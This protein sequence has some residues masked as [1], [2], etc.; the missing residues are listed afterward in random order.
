MNFLVAVQG[1]EEVTLSEITIGD[2]M[3]EGNAKRNEAYFG[4]R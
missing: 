2:A 1:D 4:V 3:R